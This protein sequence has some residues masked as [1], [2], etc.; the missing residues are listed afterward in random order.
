M[1][2]A[3]LNAKLETERSNRTLIQKD[4]PDFPSTSKMTRRKITD[5]T[6]SIN[7]ATEKKTIGGSIIL[8]FSS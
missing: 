3:K 8:L 4:L 2:I 7:P 5:E 1:A 6:T